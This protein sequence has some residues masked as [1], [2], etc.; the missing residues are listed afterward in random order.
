MAK[1]FSSKYVSVDTACIYRY[2]HKHTYTVLPFCLPQLSPLLQEETRLTAQR[3]RS[4]VVETNFCDPTKYETR[5][6][7]GLR[8]DSPCDNLFKTAIDI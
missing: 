3:K 4:W 5:D 6:L 7:K 2:P 8:V 1:F